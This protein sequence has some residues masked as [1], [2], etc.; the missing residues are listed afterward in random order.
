MTC[1][2]WVDG[3]IVVTPCIAVATKIFGCFGIDERKI[4]NKV[5]NLLCQA[6]HP[7]DKSTLVRVQ[8]NQIL[9]STTLASTR[10]SLLIFFPPSLPSL[11]RGDKAQETPQ[12]QLNT[13]RH[14]TMSTPEQ[15]EADAALARRLQDEEF[16]ALSFFP[17]APLRAP[18]NAGGP[19]RHVPSD[20]SRAPYASMRDPS[21]SHGSGFGADRDGGYPFVQ[22]RESF[23]TGDM[24]SELFRRAT[25]SGGGRLEEAA[26]DNLRE[27]GGERRGRRWEGGFRARTRGGVG[28]V[29]MEGFF[30]TRFADMGGGAGGRY[31]AGGMEIR[32]GEGF[33]MDVPIRESRY[34]R[35]NIGEMER[36]WDREGRVYGSGAGGG[37]PHEIHQHHMYERGDGQHEAMMDV[38]EMLNEMFMEMVTTEGGR[39]RMVGGSMG[40][41]GNI[42]EWLRSMLPGGEPR[43]YEDWLEVI[44]RMGGNVNRGAS[45]TEIGNLPSE[46]YRKGCLERNRMKRQMKE[47]GQDGRGRASSSRGEG[48]GGDMEEGDKCAICLGEYEEGEEVKTLP[49]FHIFHSECVDRWLKVN[50]ICPFCKQSIRPGGGDGGQ[51]V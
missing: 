18:L 45:E 43:Q 5:C 17:A 31:E 35:G 37:R 16:G 1:R 39:P 7:F 24:L 38:G 14:Y 13:K 49:C 44:E 11:C 21:R 3:G 47:G 9:I 48:E 46:K 32:D 8:Q 6:S 15:V 2:D 10:H 19:P 34:E 26:V 4:F 25:E 33:R 27:F 40:G 50:K 36:M 41:M 51:R 28:D 29:L 20:V 42:A 12:P 23:S 22:G 30:G